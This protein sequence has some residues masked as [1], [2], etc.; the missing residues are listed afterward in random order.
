M[1]KV[2]IILSLLFVHLY[3]FA[4]SDQTENP[5]WSRFD[6]N[7][8]WDNWFATL[9][10][11]D[12]VFFNRY[13]SEGNFSDRITPA[14]DI[15]AGKWIVPTLGVRMRV[16]GFRLKG[17]TNNPNNMYYNGKTNDP[18]LYK[19]LWKDI[20]VEGDILVNLS[21][22]IG[23]YRKNRF[24]ET[25][26]YFG[27]GFIDSYNETNFEYILSFGSNNIFRLSKNIDTNIDIR[28]GLVR[29]EFSGEIEAHRINDI[30]SVQLVLLT[31]LTTKNSNKS[32][33]PLIAWNTSM[34]SLRSNRR[35]KASNGKRKSIT[36]STRKSGSWKTN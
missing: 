19:Q 11:G 21:N 31:T 35:S 6:T 4:Q 13:D 3:S 16:G 18:R 22:W 10:F 26:P 7:K 36:N 2:L 28:N 30:L 15:S 24:F 29:G 8:F 23:G 5:R 34:L 27:F 25:V 33:H 14:F 17:F 1:K 32:F 12:A 9:N 20:H